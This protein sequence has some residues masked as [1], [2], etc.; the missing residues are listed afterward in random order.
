MTLEEAVAFLNGKEY[1]SEYNKEFAKELT[2]SNLVAVYGSSDDLVE[3]IGAI[4]DEC[5]AAEIVRFDPETGNVLCP[6]CGCR[7]ETIV[8]NSLPYIKVNWN[9][10]NPNWTY[11]AEFPHQ[12][13]DI[14]ED[15][16]VYCR[17]IVFSLDDV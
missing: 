15:G 1:G 10:T 8:L 17:G 11:E 2:K 9:N 16:E 14:M 6:D 12:T 7:Y 13:F 4:D 3:F 5:G